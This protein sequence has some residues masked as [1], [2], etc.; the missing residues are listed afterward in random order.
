MLAAVVVRSS[1]PFRWVEV[2]QVLRVHSATRATAAGISR[3]LDR[4]LDPPPLS[5]ATDVN[6]SSYGFVSPRQAW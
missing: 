6:T 3:R 4:L 1:I 5:A 2:K